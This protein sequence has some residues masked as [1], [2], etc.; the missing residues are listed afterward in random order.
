MEL[1]PES[2][3][4]R[5]RYKLLIGCI[6][7]RPIAFVSTVD[8]RGRANLA[9]FSFFNGVGSDP[10]TILFCPANRADGGEKDTLANCKPI[11]EGGTGE[12]VVCA[13]TEDYAREVAASAEP[14]PHGESEFELTGLATSPS[15]V[16]RA[17]RVAR[18]PW[19]FECRTIQVVRTNPGSPSGG[20]VVIGRVVHVYVDETIVDARFHIDFDRLR[21]VGRMGGIVYSTTR[22]RYEMPIGRDALTRADPFE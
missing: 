7:P 22:E 20:N 4:Q 17:P 3:A 9:P 16:V 8:A 19:A 2:L 14:L 15:R 21:A 10:M 12:F 11:E 5:D 1:D 6:V 18:S 13:A